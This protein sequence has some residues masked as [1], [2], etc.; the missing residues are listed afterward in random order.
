MSPPTRRQS[1][2]EKWTT[3]SAVLSALGFLMMV[4]GSYQAF[5]QDTGKRIAVMESQIKGLERDIA[6][7]RQDQDKRP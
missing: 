2:T 5:Q 4:Y 3:P 7:L 6:W 1:V